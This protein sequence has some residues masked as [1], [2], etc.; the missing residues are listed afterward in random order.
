MIGLTDRSS[1][2][3]WAIFARKVAI[4]LVR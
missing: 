3:G 1:L 4:D 2:H